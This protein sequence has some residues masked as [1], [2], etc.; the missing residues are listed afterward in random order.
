MFVVTYHTIIICNIVYMGSLCSG[1]IWW[2]T[3]EKEMMIRVRVALLQLLVL[4][5]FVCPATFRSGDD[6]DGYHPCR[7]RLQIS[8]ITLEWAS[9]HLFFLLLRLSRKDIRY[10]SVWLAHRIVSFCHFF[11][12]SF[13]VWT[14][15]HASRKKQRGKV[16]TWCEVR[17]R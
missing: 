6:D 2:K 4:T 5:A 13:S 11:F 14:V 16:E 10:F 3:S 15:K 17:D 8:C 1:K 7:S 9:Y 12:V